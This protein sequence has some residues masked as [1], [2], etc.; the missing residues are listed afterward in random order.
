MYKMRLLAGD[1]LWVLAGQLFSLI[2]VLAS[3]KLWA[4]YLDPE[5]VGLMGLIVGFASALVGI[6]IGPFTQTIVVTYATYALEGRKHEFRD[7]GSR[8]IVKISL[9]VLAITLC[10]GF[11]LVHFLKL[12][13]I[14]PL[15]IAG[16]FATDAWRAFEISL[17]AAARRQRQVAILH[18]GDAWFRLAF[19]WLSLA[20]FAPTAYTAI[21]GTLVGAIVFIVLVRLLTQPEAYPGRRA[22]ETDLITQRL[23]S[24]A[25]PLF[26]AMVFANITSVLNRYLIAAT[27]GLG[28][29]GL[30]VVAYGLVR[31]PYG[32]LNSVTDWTMRPALASAIAERDAAKAALARRLWLAVGGGFAIL[33]VLLFYM[34]KGPVVHILLSSEYVEASDLLS[35]TAIALALFNIANI[36]NGF[37]LTAG[38]SRSVLIS[39]AVGALSGG[40]L[41]FILCLLYG[42]PGA[43]WALAGG[44]LLQLATS[45]ITSRRLLSRQHRIAS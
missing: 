4:V 21:F 39:N 40:A 34:L 3:F 45:L 23:V 32:L 10:V 38:D 43:V 31:R 30:F 33:G 2:A 13:G 29:A 28:P 44:Y 9:L 7:A 16:L 17:F 22:E 24:L 5:E 27:I 42:L 6:A 20:S 19:L 37:S 41:T 11:P 14:A 18:C 35:G 8:I 36:F 25:K 1:G 12:Q 26:P 15:L